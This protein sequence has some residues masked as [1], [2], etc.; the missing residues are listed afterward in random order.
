[1][2]IVP[3]AVDFPTGTN[4]KLKCEGL[5]TGRHVFVSDILKMF[6]LFCFVFLFFFKNLTCSHH[7]KGLF[8]KCVLFQM[9][10]KKTIIIIDID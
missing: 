3:N 4:S 10:K 6:F 5:Y 9:G 7:L 1:M 8:S 2:L